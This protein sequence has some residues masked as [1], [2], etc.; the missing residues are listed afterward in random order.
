[1]RLPGR[2][3]P[4]LPVLL[5]LL[6]VCVFFTKREQPPLHTP[7]MPLPAEETSPS[8]L[9]A[10]EEDIFRI[11][12]TATGEIL[13][14]SAREFLPGAVATEM[15]LSM[16]EEALKAQAV[17]CYT[18]YAW[19]RAQH[20]EN[21]YDFTCDTAAWQVYVTLQDMQARWGDDY[22]RCM[23]IL[24]RV[25]DTVYG[26]CLTLNNEPICA[27]YF[28]ISSGHTENSADV[29]G[30]EL[31]Y[32]SAVASPGDAFAPGY[33]TTAA[34]SPQEV[35]EATGADTPE[36]PTDLVRV[37]SRSVSGGVTSV[38]VG[39][40]TLTGPQLRTALGLRSANFTPVYAE[41]Q[42]VFT[43][44]GWGHGVGMSQAGADY[45]AGC[46][47]TFEEILAW[48]YPGAQLTRAN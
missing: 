35:A 19:Q 30:G 43:V 7:P 31:A 3:R 23:E 22:D 38:A 5:L 4:L 36:D 26:C 11:L 25:A 8:P 45:M 29:W 40:V 41:G 16:H 18:Q 12:D 34:F 39:N 10:E 46:G 44:N 9:P 17:A 28:A 27:T 13:T 37:L 48:Y 24:N 15:T 14:V 42:W 20:A 21:D 33:R 1:M 32:L 6:A 2:R 47:S